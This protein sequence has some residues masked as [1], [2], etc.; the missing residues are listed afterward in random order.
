M[1]I[2]AS[3][4]AFGGVVYPI[5]L[6]R[7]IKDVGFP[8][9]VRTSGFLTLA[10]LCVSCLTMRTRLPLTK[11]VTYRDAVDFSGFKD[12]RYALCA[13]GAFLYV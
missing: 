8:W 5:M 2:V 12:I 1:G 7:L 3:G 11:Q 6:Q 4:S 13:V 10:C 9:A